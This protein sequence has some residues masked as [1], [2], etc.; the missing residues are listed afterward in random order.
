MISSCTTSV[1]TLIPVTE[2]TIEKET[3]DQETPITKESSAGN[4]NET[5][6]VE[7]I[8]I[9]ES[10]PSLPVEE[11]ADS[12][13]DPLDISD[14]NDQNQSNNL[15][16]EDESDNAKTEE[17]DKPKSKTG[18]LGYQLYRCTF[19]DFSCSNSTDFKKHS[20]NSQQCRSEESIAKPFVCVHCRK[21][22]RNPGVLVDHI[23]THGKLR[24]MCSLCEE[25]FPTHTKAR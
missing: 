21:R 11:A 23:Q 17:T 9:G 20:V 14:V 4:D 19:C 15:S 13:I 25:K 2:S 22:L 7:Q 6:P 12:E 5:A 18:L 16:S 1:P 10:N 8:L 3:I 24:F